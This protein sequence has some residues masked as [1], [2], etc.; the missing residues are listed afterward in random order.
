[1]IRVEKAAEP[2]TDIMTDAAIMGLFAAHI[3]AANTAQTAR[4]YKGAVVRFGHWLKRNGIDA[5]EPGNLAFY[6]NDM[7][8]QLRKSTAQTHLYAIRAF[9]RWAEREGICEDIAQNV[10]AVNTS[11]ENRARALT[12]EQVESVLITMLDAMTEAAAAANDGI[13]DA[14][15]DMRTH[16][17]ARDA[18]IFTLAVTFGLGPKEIISLKNKDIEELDGGGAALATA[19]GLCVMEADGIAADIVRLYLGWCLSPGRQIKANEKDK[20]KAFLYAE[21]RQT[22]PLF[23]SMSDRN[24]GGALCIR[25]VRRIIQNTL[26]AAAV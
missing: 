7:R 15:K 26:G 13:Y 12:G 2:I 5:P 6:V 24:Y 18:A 3:E 14:R 16:R 20:W 25:S 4:L 17:L 1:L 21:K 11:R 9:F 19:R 8:G 23:F 22:L 10:K